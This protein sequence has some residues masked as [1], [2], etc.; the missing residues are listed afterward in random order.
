ML[1][2]QT[3]KLCAMV[4]AFISASSSNAAVIGFDELPGPNGAPMIP[5]SEE[6]FTV[7]PIGQSRWVTSLTYGHPAPFVQ[8]YRFAN[9]PAISNSVLVDAGGADFIFSF[10]EV[11][12]SVTTI[13]YVIRGYKGAAELFSMSGIVPN[14]FGGF[15]LVQNTAYYTVL[16]DRLLI[17]LTN[18]YLAFPGNNP[19]GL[20]NIGAT[21]FMRVPEPG[22]IAVLLTAM[23]GSIAI[24]LRPSRSTRR[25]QGVQRLSAV[26]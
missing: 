20:D 7:T 13:P 9:E 24:R 15:A 1:R 6:G 22:G 26:G 10:V 18:P 3:T 21:T 5:Y 16:I 12:S 11:Y 2:S 19:V 4:F 8:F 17:E 25:V 14:T 23:A